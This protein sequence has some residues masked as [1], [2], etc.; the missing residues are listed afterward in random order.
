MKICVIG[1]GGIAFSSHGPALSRYAA[2]HPGV[3]LAACCDVQLERAEDFRASFGF[4]RTYHDYTEMVRTE[5][6]QVVCLLVPPQFTCS[7]ACDLLSHRV[8]LFME[9]PPGLTQAEVHRI[10]QAASESGTPHLVAFNRRFTPLVQRFRSI[11][12]DQFSPQD[13]QYIDYQMIRAGR[14]DPD[15]S[16]TA[17]H[18]IDAVSWLAGSPYSQVA[19]RYQNFPA[20]GETIANFF[21]DGLL[22]SG[23][24]AHLAF[25]PVSGALTERAA[26]Y[27]QDHTFYLEL[28]LRNGN[29]GLGRLVHVEKGKRVL[30]ITGPEAAGG[31]EDWLLNGFYTEHEAFFNALQ[32][33]ERP[34]AGIETAVQSVAIMEAVRA[35]KAFWSQDEFEI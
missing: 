14:T 28:P 25:C 12:I 13:I 21:L 26:I 20:L 10:A 7:I 33:G 3:D 6:P 29:D 15:F 16:T 30:D 4:R 17:V 34:P 8:P 32:L 23:A 18:G 9:K 19:C 5:H 24:L 22:D 27:L 31:E 35:R 2:S 1:C 11:F